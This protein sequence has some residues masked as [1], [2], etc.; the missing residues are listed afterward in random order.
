MRLSRESGDRLAEAN[1][2][3]MQTIAKMQFQNGANSP[4]AHVVQKDSRVMRVS[5][6]Y[7]GESMR[8]ICHRGESPR[9]PK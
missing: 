8:H 3:S 6:L 2:R 5:L 9:N 7:L 1:R 4:I